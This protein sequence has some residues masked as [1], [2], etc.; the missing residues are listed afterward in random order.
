[1]IMVYGE[2]K[3]EHKKGVKYRNFKLCS[4]KVKEASEYD[5][6]GIKN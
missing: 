4:T 5:H 3:N 2:R 1:M 6:V